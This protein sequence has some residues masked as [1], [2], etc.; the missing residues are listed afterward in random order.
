MD[1]SKMEISTRNFAPLN[2]IKIPIKLS[3]RGWGWG[4]FK[5]LKSTC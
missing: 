2:P 5:K 4:I 1:A 3:R